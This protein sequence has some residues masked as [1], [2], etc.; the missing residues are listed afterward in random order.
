[1]VPKAIEEVTGFALLAAAAALGAIRRFRGRVLS[2]TGFHDLKVTGV[3][4][5]EFGGSQGGLACRAVSTA[6]LIA[7][8]WSI[9][10]LAHT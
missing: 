3:E 7:S 9:I 2:V 8:R 10:V 1:M 4:A 6:V 5:V